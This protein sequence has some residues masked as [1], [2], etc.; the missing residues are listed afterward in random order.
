MT[1]V[2]FDDDPLAAG[3]RVPLTTVR[4]DSAAKGRAADALFTAMDAARA[5][6]PAEPTHTLLPTD[7]VIRG[8]S[9]PPTP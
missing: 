2:G 4:Q 3:D 7:L 6:E 8:S 9:G 5:G 1:V